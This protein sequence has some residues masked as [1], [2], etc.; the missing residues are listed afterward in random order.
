VGPERIAER[1][2]EDLLVLTLLVRHPEEA[3]RPGV[4]MAPRERR[5]TNEHQ[6][7]QRIAVQAQRAVDESVVRGILHGR[8]QHAVQEDR[9]GLVV[10][11]VLVPRSLGDLHDDSED[12]TGTVHEASLVREGG[13]IIREAR[14]AEV[15]CRTR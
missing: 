11:L 6:R 7:I 4:D 8:E 13:A 9:A 12:L 10:E 14:G 15:L 2:A 1:N 5:L 3:D